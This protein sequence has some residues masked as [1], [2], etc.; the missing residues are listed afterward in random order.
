MREKSKLPHPKRRPWIF[1]DELRPCSSAMVAPQ[2]SQFHPHHIAGTYLVCQSFDYV[3][4]SDGVSDFSSM[5]NVKGQVG[6]SVSSRM[7]IYPNHTMRRAS[8]ARYQRSN[9]A[10][11][12]VLNISH[13]G[14]EWRNA[15]NRVE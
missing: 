12:I 15:V 6:Q 1:L 3:L 11:S 8:G 2:L 9:A 10:P 7:A 5:W 13:P 14:S 4:N